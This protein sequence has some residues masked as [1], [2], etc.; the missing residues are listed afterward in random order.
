MTADKSSGQ[1]NVPSGLVTDGGEATAAVMRAL[2]SNIWEKNK[3]PKERD[4]VSV[5]PRTEKGK[6]QAVREVPYDKSYQPYQ[7]SHVSLHPQQ[8]GK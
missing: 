5:H 8:T 7:E 4:P 1:D 3:L 6:T 2:C